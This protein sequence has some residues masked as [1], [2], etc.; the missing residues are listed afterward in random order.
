VAET[1]DKSGNANDEFKLEAQ[2]EGEKETR[3]DAGEWIPAFL[4][5]LASTANV[6]LACRQAGISRKTAYQWKEENKEFADRWKDAL[7]D[8]LDILEWDG[9]K[10]ARSSSDKLLMYF[11]DVHRYGRK[12]QHEHSGPGGGPIPV[13]DVISIIDEEEE[14]DE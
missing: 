10:R 8:A 5:T 3:S 11:L 4:T 6:Y 1:D 7:E 9:R 12:Y 13:K 14:D 2:K